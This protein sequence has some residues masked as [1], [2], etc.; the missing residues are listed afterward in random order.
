MPNVTDDFFAALNHRH[1]PLLAHTA[2]T[3]RF[4]IADADVVTHRY[5][6]IDNGD[7]EVFDSA[8]D[9]D[10]VVTGTR[11]VFEGVGSGELNP[12]AAYL[13]GALTAR[14]DI[15]LLVMFQRVFPRPGEVATK[16]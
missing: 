10:C 2:G 11:G 13:R 8:A 15:E 1:E 5:L 3:V 4:D 14:G 9:A 7:I 16:T 12:M 6:T